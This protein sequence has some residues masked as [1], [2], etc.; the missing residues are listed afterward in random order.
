MWCACIYEYDKF[1]IY[2]DKNGAY[3]NCP[4]CGHRN[5]VSEQEKS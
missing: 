5:S 1:D 2:H 4:D 3:V